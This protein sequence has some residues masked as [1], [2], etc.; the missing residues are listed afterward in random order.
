M[1][2]RQAGKPINQA[3]VQRLQVRCAGLL[4]GVRVWV[5]FGVSSSPENHTLLTQTLALTLTLTVL[6]SG[7]FTYIGGA[8][9]GTG[10]TRPAE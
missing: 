10:T 4:S 6:L 9:T 7:G 8:D 3:I 5:R 2:D 1:A